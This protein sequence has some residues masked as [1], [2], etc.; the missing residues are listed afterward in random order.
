[1]P[2]NSRPGKRLSQAE[3]WASLMRVESAGD[4]GVV[5]QANVRSEPVLELKQSTLAVHHYV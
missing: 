3:Q 5:R 2:I 4:W 1:M